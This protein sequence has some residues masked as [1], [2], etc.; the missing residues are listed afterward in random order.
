M[1]QIN[2]NQIKTNQR[3]KA[4][5]ILFIISMLIL[6]G[7]GGYFVYAQNLSKTSETNSVAQVDQMKNIVE[8]NTA[9][10]NDD[11]S[12]TSDQPAKDPNR[13]YNDEGK[14]SYIL[15]DEWKNKDLIF[16]V[17][18]IDMEPD[19]G[20]ACGDIN[21]RISSNLKDSLNAKNTNSDFTQEFKKM[22]IG[23]Y[24]S[25]VLESDNGVKYALGIDICNG[26]QVDEKEIANAIRFRGISYHGNIEIS[27]VYS[28]DQNII[29]S[30]EIKIADL[31]KLAEDLWNH[32][33]TNSNIQSLFSLFEQMM[34]T[35]KF[36]NI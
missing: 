8:D 27:L 6:V 33:N 35:L 17:S 28:V 21:P 20:G 23:I 3:S 13:Y 25:K 34:T 2:Q 36:E 31:S 32:K 5:L 16:N 26:A 14:F 7:V 9:N 1:T 15:P 19:S 11:E 10:T 24:K 29:K 4:S 22:F 12:T 30:E 18:P